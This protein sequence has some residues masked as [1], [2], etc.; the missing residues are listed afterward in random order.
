[1]SCDIEIII[2]FFLHFLGCCYFLIDLFVVIVNL[3]YE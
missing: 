3:Y 1:M 2:I